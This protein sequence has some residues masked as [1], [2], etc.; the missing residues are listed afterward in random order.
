MTNFDIFDPAELA[1]SAEERKASYAAAAPFPSIA[2]DNFL[3]ADLYRALSDEFPGPEAQ[4][5]HEFKSG[6]ENK[7]LQSNNF[8]AIPPLMRMLIAECNGPAFVDFLERLSGIPNLVPDP[9]LFGG[10][11]HQTK[12]GGHLGLH[13]DYNFHETWKLDRR[14][15]A[16]LYF[17]DE[18]R[19]EWGGHLELWDRDVKTRIQSIAPIGNRLVVFNTDERSWH[20]HPDPLQ[21]PVGVTRRSLA[22]Y[23]YSNGRPDSEAGDAHNTVF[24]ER[25]GEAFRPTFRDHLRDWVPPALVRLIRRP[26]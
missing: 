9:H 22:L 16:I 7:K 12:P 23:Y 10:G 4:L 6:P 21:C 20:G 5:W 8:Y 25:P 15:N 26:R 18:W 19:D 24:R 14:L 13:I 3:P 11:L 2:I 17:N 1:F